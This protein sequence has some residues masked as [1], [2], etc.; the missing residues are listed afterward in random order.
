[1]DLSI[2]FTEAPKNVMFLRNAGFTLDDPDTG[3]VAATFDTNVA[4]GFPII[5]I[6]KGI[7]KGKTFHITAKALQK[8]I[9]DLVDDTEVE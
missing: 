6:H 2:K 1:M 9:T 7:H 8:F 5:I 4:G 3:E